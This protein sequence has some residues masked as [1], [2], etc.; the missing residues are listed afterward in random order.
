MK[1]VSCSFPALG[2]SPFLQGLGR[3][4]LAVLLT[5]SAWQIYVLAPLPGLIGV[6][7]APFVNMYLFF[8]G[9]S[10]MQRGILHWQTA[11]TARRLRLEPNWGCST[12]GYLLV[13]DGKGIWVG[14]GRAG[15]LSELASLCCRTEERAFL[16]ELRKD[17]D[18]APLVSVGVKDEAELELVS[19]RLAE[20]ARGHGS[21]LRVEHRKTA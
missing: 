3:W 4:A 18:P 17:E 9:L 16:L 10:F 12:G 11:R 1:P 5:C 19:A 8:R 13:D 14:N 6:G 7:L 15:R 2:P 20:S 21:A